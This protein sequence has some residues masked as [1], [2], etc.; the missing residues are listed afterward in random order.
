MRIVPRWDWLSR[1]HRRRVHQLDVMYG[2][3]VGDEDYREGHVFIVGK[4]R[5]LGFAYYRTSHDVPDSA[6]IGWFVAPRHGRTCLAKLLAYLDERYQSQTLYNSKE[7][8]KAY[9]VRKKL[10]KNA[11]FVT[12]RKTNTGTFMRRAAVIH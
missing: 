7:P 5:L 6:H 12:T 3:A 4:R 2:G 9:A 1:T 8:E 11:G 10:Y